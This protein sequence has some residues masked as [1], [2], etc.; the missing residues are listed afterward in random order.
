MT[1]FEV[2]VGLLLFD[3]LMEKLCKKHNMPIK[4]KIPMIPKLLWK[5]YR[6][7]S[8]PDLN[9]KQKNTGKNDPNSSKK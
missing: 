2:E 8:I 5:L 1:V 6:S 7:K 9:K 3:Q 4:P